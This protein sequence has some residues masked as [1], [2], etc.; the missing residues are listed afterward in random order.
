[1]QES[2]GGVQG[3]GAWQTGQLRGCRVHLSKRQQQK[4]VWKAL[5]C[6]ACWQCT[7]WLPPHTRHHQVGPA[8]VLV[9]GEAD[10]DEAAQGA[11]NLGSS[12]GHGVGAHGLGHAVPLCLVVE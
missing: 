4:V 6:T 7:N 9:G 8:D 12:A 10:V 3:P 11:G 5:N 2:A 1:M